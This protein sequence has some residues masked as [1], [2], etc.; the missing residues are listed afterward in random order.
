MQQVEADNVRTKGFAAL[1]AQNKKV[2]SVIGPS[3]DRRH[4]VVF[5]SNRE[6][7]QLRRR[8]AQSSSE[9]GFT[10]YRRYSPPQPLRRSK[11]ALREAARML[12]L[13]PPKK[14]IAQFVVTAALVIV[15]ATLATSGL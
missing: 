3:M 14:S 9:Q 10:C 6:C 15:D 12:L 8:A 1:S 13:D 4:N 5:S 7:E 2:V 11:R